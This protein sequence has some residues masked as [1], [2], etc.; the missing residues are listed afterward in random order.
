MIIE[1]W[2]DHIEGLRKLIGKESTYATCQKYNAAK[3]FSNFLRIK[4]K[5]SDVPI[6]S[7]D[8]Y[9]VTEF[10]L[11]LKFPNPAS[12]TPILIPFPDKLSNCIYIL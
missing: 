11:Y 8:H 9:M 3:H 12:I 6:K 2:E 10:G 4:Y 1:I 5:V 7:I